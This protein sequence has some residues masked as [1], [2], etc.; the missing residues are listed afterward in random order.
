MII[1]VYNED[2]LKIETLSTDSYEAKDNTVYGYTEMRI[3][4]MNKKTPMI[5]EP[6]DGKESRVD[7][8]GEIMY[9][10]DTAIECGIMSDGDR[11]YFR[12]MLGGKS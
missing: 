12:N 6:K 2:K 1:K 11:N 8:V 4:L 10:I 5:R 3:D 7:S 9:D